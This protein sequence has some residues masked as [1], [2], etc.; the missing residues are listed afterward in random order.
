MAAR[1]SARRPSPRMRARARPSSTTE[2]P[3][4]SPSRISRRSGFDARSRG[5]MFYSAAD[6]RAAARMARTHAVSAFCSLTVYR[7]VPLNQRVMP[8][9]LGP[10]LRDAHRLATQRDR[11]APGERDGLLT[12]AERDAGRAFRQE[13]DVPTQDRP[14]GLREGFLLRPRQ[15]DLATRSVSTLDG[16]GG[17]EG[18]RAPAHERNVSNAAKRSPTIANGNLR[19]HHSG[20]QVPG[21]AQSLALAGC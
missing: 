12:L 2:R 20:D 3:T 14:R 8:P 4:T 10:D 9:P 5:E 18:R 1:S 11:N 19:R 6:A 21:A 15:P 13:R 16:D 17:D 7:I